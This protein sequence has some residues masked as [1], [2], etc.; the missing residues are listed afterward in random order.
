MSRCSNSTGEIGGKRGSSLAA[1]TAAWSS[2]R[3]SGTEVPR[4]P[5]QE[6]NCPPR[7]RLTNEPNTGT[8]A[9]SA[10]T[11]SKGSGVCDRTAAI[12]RRAAAQKHP[13]LLLRAELRPIGDQRGSGGPGTI[14]RMVAG[15]G[16]RAGTV[17]FHGLFSLRGD[18]LWGDLESRPTWTYV[19]GGG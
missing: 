14:R 9:T 1:R 11:S 13:L 8:S 15:G 19:L 3:Q 5:Q 2:A 18:L 10:R 6:R 7:F 17:V 16:G 12:T 4:N